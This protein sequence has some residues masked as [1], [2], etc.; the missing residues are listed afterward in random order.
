[1]WISRTR[2]AEEKR[3]SI[4]KETMMPIT[5]VTIMIMR[6][7][8][9]LFLVPFLIP[10]CSSFVSNLLAIIPNTVSYTW[11][12]VS[13]SVTS[14]LFFSRVLFSTTLCFQLEV[15]EEGRTTFTWRDSKY[16]W[17]WMTESSTCVWIQSSL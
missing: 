11:N 9:F 13:M 10:H 14:D 5:I 16:E 2:Q 17:F 7:I 15:S 3:E 1:M 12:R 8:I 4:T 6:V